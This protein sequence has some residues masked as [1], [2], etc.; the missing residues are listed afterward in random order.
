MTAYTGGIIA[1]EIIMNEPPAPGILIMIL[2][3][4]GWYHHE[5]HRFLYDK[6][7]KDV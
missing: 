3:W 7:L 5:P 4:I 6:N 2:L 1:A